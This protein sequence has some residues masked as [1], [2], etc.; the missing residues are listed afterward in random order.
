MDYGDYID[1][2][3]GFDNLSQI[4]QVKYVAYF[5]T[6]INKSDH[7]ASPAVAEVFV[8]ENLDK[9]ANVADCLNKLCSRTPSILVKKGALYSFHRTAKKALD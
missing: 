7:F 9:P 1:K 5:Y 2:V 6:I 8:K 3:D 4:E